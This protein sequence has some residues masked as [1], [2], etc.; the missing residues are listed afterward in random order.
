MVNAPEINRIMTT[1]TATA[2][3]PAPAAATKQ[4]SMPYVSTG[5]GGV[6]NVKKATK[7]AKAAAAVD[8]SVGN[9]GSALS[10]TT[11]NTANGAL[12]P[13][14]DEDCTLT[15]VAT[16]SSLG[17]RFATGRGGAGNMLPK[18]E[19]PLS[20]DA[21]SDAHA[22]LVKKSDA[23][24]SFV[25]TGRG[26]A[27][28]FKNAKTG[29]RASATEAAKERR[30]SSS[31]ADNAVNGRPGNFRRPSLFGRGVSRIGDEVAVDDDDDDDENA[32]AGGSS[33]GRPAGRRMSTSS[34][35]AGVP[36]EESFLGK[37]RRRMSNLGQ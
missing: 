3:A 23:D 27:G 11:S 14:N 22:A 26:G 30:K 33:S 34:S 8:P 13:E 29:R 19:V 36:S 24:R 18:G 35:P 25:V 12:A 16:K 7:V 2:P 17:A 5:R 21:Q 28:N 1:T 4:K 10:R 37:L 6:G 31:A 9:F 15:R 32:A 20:M